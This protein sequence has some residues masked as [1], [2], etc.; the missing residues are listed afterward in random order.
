MIYV[1]RDMDD[2]CYVLDDS[3]GSV[4]LLS[5]ADVL[6]A[7]ND[8]A[9]IT[10]IDAEGTVTPQVHPMNSE[11]VKIVPDSEKSIFDCVEH[12][13]ELDSIDDARVFLMDCGESG[14]YKFKET[15]GDMILFTS[16]LLVNRDAKVNTLINNS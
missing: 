1:L 6:E 10:G 2:S 9:E 14:V 5:K 12:L 3:D 8:G 11:D 13:E 15:Y 16:N 7:L 4:E